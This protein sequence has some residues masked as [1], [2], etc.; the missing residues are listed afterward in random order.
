MANFTPFKFTSVGLDLEYEAQAGKVLNFSKFVLGDGEYGGSIRDLTNLINPI[1]EEPITRFEIVETGAKKRI[2]IGFSLDTTQITEGF[3]LREIGLFAKDPDTGNDIL[4]FY[5][6]AGETADYI[7]NNTS[8]TVTTKLINAEVYIDDVAEITATIDSSLV[9]ALAKDTYN[10]T[11]VDE[12]IENI[13]IKFEAD[14]EEINDKLN[15]LDENK[16]N[17]PSKIA[18]GENVY[19]EDAFGSPLVSL[20]GEGKYKQVTTTGKNKFLAP[21]DLQTYNC[22]YTKID[23]N[24]FTLSTEHSGTTNWSGYIEIPIDISLLEPNETYTISKEN[25]VSGVE[26]DGIGSLR[27]KINGTLGSIRQT[28][29]LT[30]NTPATLESISIIFYIAYSSTLSG[31]SEIIFNKIQL[32][33]E[34]T[35]TDF[36]P[37]TGGQPSPNPDYPQE[38]TTVTEAE[39]KGVGKNIID[40]SDRSRY[41]LNTSGTINTYYNSGFHT[42]KYSI[43]TSNS[44]TVSFKALKSIDLKRIYLIFYDKNLNPLNKSGTVAYD[45]NVTAN[46]IYTK[47]I[48]I[49]DPNIAYCRIT[50]YSWTVDGT[51]VNLIDN[52]EEYVTDFQVEA[53]TEATPYEPYQESILP[54]DLQG[55]EL[56]ELDKLLIDRKGNVAIEKNVGKIAFDGSERYT[57]QS[58]NEYGIANFHTTYKENYNA[59]IPISNYFIQ[60]YTAIANTMIECMYFQPTGVYFRIKTSTASTVEEY[61]AW[62]QEHYTEVYYTLSTPQIINLGKIENP[63]IFKGINNIVVETNLGNMPIEVEYSITD[64][65]ERFSEIYKDISTIDGK[66]NEIGDIPTKLSELENDTGFKSITASTEDLEPGVSE[67]AEGHIHLTYE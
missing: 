53:G 45:R 10:K 22:T 4:M 23:D 1:R 27:V 56:C 65:D 20:S 67:L 51:S 59:G 26:F 39:Y 17:I 21:N 16:Y 66:V 24:S 12:K 33:K 32:E 30:F 43:V 13:N 54:I 38:I 63:E 55:N 34:S 50:C 2:R 25:L 36:E 60:K 31:T 49:S 62:L 6:N 52:L 57:L 8:T 5:T 14:I 58:I 37:Y 7:S 9:Y 35:K 44:I 29:E 3:Y 61:K 19:I 15:Y 42:N 41:P 28:G 46:T 48:T 11:E 64:L 40:I 47:T 18:S